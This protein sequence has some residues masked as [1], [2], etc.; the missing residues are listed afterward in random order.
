MKS[1]FSNS[2]AP[3]TLHIKST[4]HRLQF[5]QSIHAVFFLLRL[6]SF[7]FAKVN[8]FMA[9][10][11]HSTDE[12]VNFPS[13]RIGILPPWD[14]KRPSPVIAYVEIRCRCSRIWSI[15]GHGSLRSCRK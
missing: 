10:I 8:D 2:P 15:R 3:T 11:D 6:Y 1:G 5:D 4:T 9:F 13:K 7:F 14:D 12:M